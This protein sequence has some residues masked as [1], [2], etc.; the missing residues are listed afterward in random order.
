MAKKNIN[1]DESLGF[2]SDEHLRQVE[3]ELGTAMHTLPLPQSF[4]L[5]SILGFLIASILTLS[6]RIS[7]S[8]GFAF[9]LVFVMMF[10]ASF[11]SITPSGRDG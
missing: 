1:Y 9:C 6:G 3:K 11:V 4:F 8:W 2:R 7:L 5:T 10:I